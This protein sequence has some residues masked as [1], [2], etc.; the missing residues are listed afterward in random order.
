MSSAPGFI[1]TGKGGVQ[2][3]LS[4][5]FKDCYFISS[6]NKLKI[7]HTIKQLCIHNIMTKHENNAIQKKICNQFKKSTLRVKFN[8][9]NFLNKS[10]TTTLPL[11]L[12]CPTFPYP[13]T[14]SFV[15]AVML[16]L[17]KTVGSCVVTQTT[18]NI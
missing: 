18:F 8:V 2:S 9:S 17:S 10:K 6:P 3:T 12:L 1:F 4:Y 16:A 5:I 15:M 7:C 14:F 11:A 13:Q